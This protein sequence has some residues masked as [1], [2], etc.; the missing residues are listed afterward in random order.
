MSIDTET[1]SHSYRCTPQVCEFITDHLGI[2]IQSHKDS[3]SE[4]TLI[5]DEDQIMDK[6][7]CNET[8]KLFYQN[9]IKYPCYSQNWGKS[10][11]LDHFQDVCVMLYPASMRAY[12]NETLRDI[13]P[14]SR[15]KLYVAC[16]RANNNLFLIE[17][18]K[19]IHLKY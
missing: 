13:A 5:T 8:V 16:T 14:S 7:E 6:F 18:N 12:Q 11:G 10:K 17:E 1:L 9:H 15:N 3:S 19:V 2:D 4:V